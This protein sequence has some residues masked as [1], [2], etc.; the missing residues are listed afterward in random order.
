MTFNKSL[1]IKSG[2]CVG[3]AA[4][5][6]MATQPAT[7]AFQ[8]ATGED[9]FTQDEYWTSQLHDFGSAVTWNVADGSTYASAGI[10][11]EITALADNA[12]GSGTLTQRNLASYPKPILP[13]DL[14]S[15]PSNYVPFL[16]TY[17]RVLAGTNSTGGAEV[18]SMAWRNRTDIEVDNRGYPITT[19]Q[20]PPMAYDSYGIVSDVVDLTGIAGT[21]VLEM[22]YSQPALI[23]EKAGV[24]E[25]TYAQQG[26][27]YLS[28]FEDPA[29]AAGGTDP[30]QEWVNAV[31]GNSGVGVSAV[32]N[33]LGTYADFA[34]AN[35][36]TEVNLDD[37]L[38]SWGVD[39]ATDTVWAVLDHNSEFGVVPEPGSLALLAVGSALI[40]YR[41]RRA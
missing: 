19:Q 9:A 39:T 40:G 24:T 3:A 28:W 29:N 14:M 1:L 17:A 8:A 35:S 16:G 18:V 6:L 11:S 33:Y 36:I 7:A 5:A 32:T 22:E 23:I 38:G 34:A 27:L 10:D 31:D 2:L 13:T 20:V 21:F 4:S 30:G 25:D 37:Y 41:R 15:H 26:F 12:A